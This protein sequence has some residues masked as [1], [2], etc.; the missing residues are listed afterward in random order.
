LLQDA[1]VLQVGLFP[2]NQAS[3]AAAVQPTPT[4][5]PANGQAAA[6]ST[7]ELPSLISLIV[8]PQD[9]VTLNYLI[10]SGSQLTMVL[11]GAGDEQR[12]QTEAVTL[13]YLMDQYNIPVP[14]KLPYGLEPRI[15]TINV[16]SVATPTPAPK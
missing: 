15:D 16:P 12:I 4:A 1:V 10:N 6:A 3:G 14:A 5:A 11:R 13:Q 7:D 8:S 9:A 2:S